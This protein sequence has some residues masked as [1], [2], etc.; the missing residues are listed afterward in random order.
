MRDIPWGPQPPP[1]SVRSQAGVAMNA[2]RSQLE[3]T[4]VP[5]NPD[6]MRR[7]GE[8]K[9]TLFA[10]LP[11][12]EQDSC[13]IPGS[14]LNG[15]EKTITVRSLPWIT[16]CRYHRDHYPSFRAGS[17]VLG[18][19]HRLSL[20]RSWSGSLSRWHTTSVSG[21]ATVPI[22]NQSDMAR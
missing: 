14:S 3:R 16:A 8:Y 12:L 7:K 6:E 5:T 1:R 9:S 20:L 15:S 18:P 11:E 13:D 4:I 10:R 17:G 21:I 2:K 19:M 22:S